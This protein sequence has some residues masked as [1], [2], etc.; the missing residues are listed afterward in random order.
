MRAPSRRVIASSL[1]LAFVLAGCSESAPRRMLAPRVSFSASDADATGQYLVSMKNKAGSDCAS[2]VAALGGT[3]I[4]VHDGT[5]FAFVS[6]LT[7][8]AAA[9]VAAFADVADVQ[10]DVTTTVTPAA[11]ALEQVADIDAQSQAAPA[12]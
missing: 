5:G 8:A 3:V 2:R 6:G 12:S 7:P 4:Y 11:M 9:S 1:V 10:A